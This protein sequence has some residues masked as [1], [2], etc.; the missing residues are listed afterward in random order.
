LTVYDQNYQ[1][2]GQAQSTNVSGDLV[3]VQIPQ[4]NPQA[5]RYY[6]KVDSPVGNVFAVG[7][8][9]LSITF[10]GRML[11]D[12]NS[13]P[14]TLRGPYDALTNANDMAQLLS[15]PTNVFFNSDLG[16]SQ[17][18]QTAQIL[19]STPG[20]TQDMNYQH[21]ASLSS[22][23]DVNYYTIPASA[24]RSATAQV[25]TATA[26]QMPV[27]G[28]VPAVSVYDGGTNPVASNILLNGNGTYSV[29]ATNLV[30]AANYYVKVAPAQP[31]QTGNYSLSISFGNVPA[32]MPTI[33]SKTVS[34]SRPQAS[35]ELYIGKSQLFQFVLSAGMAGVPQD[36]TVRMELY[37]N[38][39]TLLFT[40]T[41][42]AGNTVSGSSVFL[43]P[44]HYRVRF[45]FQS[46]SAAAPPL[47]FNL[48]GTNL[49]DP[50]GAASDDPT[51]QPMY[52]SDGSTYTY[53]DGTTSSN[54]YYYQPSS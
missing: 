48:R 26:V 51:M 41:A 20:Y 39:G 38:A 37:N 28:V 6:V 42:Q 49:S 21:V 46:S 47:L 5:Q 33:T 35:D 54:P 52:T 1:F 36:G 17:T 27:N 15:N 34:T 45:T 16:T 24:V 53:P 14:A 11:V 31:G 23:S 29:Q 50:I 30:P 43:T 22:V 7:R 40:L 18:F 12:P 13:L 10:D 44:G 9:A 25:L 3:S 2:L 32:S 19:L 8:F 4:N